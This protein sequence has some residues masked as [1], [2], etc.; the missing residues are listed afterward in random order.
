MLPVQTRDLQ[1]P[2]E[3]KPVLHDYPKRAPSP[4]VIADLWSLCD[5]ICRELNVRLRVA[6]ID[7]AVTIRQGAGT[8][9]YSL[10]LPDGER[11]IAVVSLLPT[12]RGGVSCG[13][14][15]GASESLACTYVE[16]AVEDG[17]PHWRIPADGVALDGDAIVDLFTRVFGPMYMAPRP[18][19]R[20]CVRAGTRRD[21]A[22]GIRP[23]APSSPSPR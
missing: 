5:A 22:G 8:R 1:V 18:G 13:A 7:R 3:A 15:I 23:C 9:R 11:F 20:A 16:P 21:G 19:D 14:Y 10:D 4:P 12:T 6:A 2:A 17:Q